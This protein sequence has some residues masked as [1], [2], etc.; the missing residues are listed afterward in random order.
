MTTFEGPNAS[1][2]GG[3]GSQQESCCGWGGLVRRH[4][5]LGF[6]LPF[7]V[8]MGVGAFE[9]IRPP[10]KPKPQAILE[11]GNLP[12]AGQQAPLAPSAQPTE[13][14]NPSEAG[15]G[16][17]KNSAESK[18]S[19]AAPAASPSKTDTLPEANWAGIPY[20]AYPAVYTLKVLLTC[21]AILLVWPVYREFPC[22]VSLLAILVGIGGLIIWL[23]FSQLNL[24]RKWLEPIGLGAFVDLGAR[25]GFNPFR[26]FQEQP[27]WMLW[28]FV[29]LRLFGM[30]IVVALVEEFF[31]RGFLM[32]YVVQADWWTV[33]VGRVTLAALIAC[34][35]YAVLSHPAE[36]FGASVWFLFVTLLAYKT[37]NIW[38]CVVAHATTNALLGAYILLLSEWKYW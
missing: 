13:Q 35:L 23:G 25:S 18:E 7:V 27:V 32:R 11:Q 2:S 24:E 30:V 26:V 10:L 19:Q 6:V 9:P 21:L 8:Y 20:S 34:V 14:L 31:L 5:W 15:G 3:V 4:R 17:G 37:K 1:V 33:P 16:E 29:A 12:E 22:R 36:L 38:D 28:G